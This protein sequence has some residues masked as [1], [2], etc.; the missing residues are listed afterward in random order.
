[1]PGNLSFW[2]TPLWFLSVGVTL[3][4]AVLVVLYSLLWLVSR[5]AAAAVLR[6]VQESVL[7]WI[8]YVVLV[9]VALCFL[10]TPMMPWRSVIDSV[11][12]LP[13]V[14]TKQVTVTIPP[15]TDDQQV[16][17][18]F[19]SDELQR[20]SFAA[21]Q[22]VIV[23]VE[24]MKAYSDPLIE[25]VA[26]EPYVW[27]P[28]SKIDRKF[29]GPITSLYVTNQSDAPANLTIESTTDVPIVEARQ[30]FWT[31]AAVVGVYLIYLLQTWLLPSLSAI[32][33]ATAKEAVAQPLYLLALFGGMGLLLLVRLH[34]VQHVRRRREDVQGL[35]PDD[36]H[37]AGDPRRRCGRRA[38]R[39][40]TKS[41]AARPSRCSRSRSAAGSSCSASFSAS[42]GRSC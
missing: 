38:F 29:T 16:D 36:D 12:R 33:L 15:R 32:A 37:G 30:I 4:A 42:S 7:Q 10:A 41:K 11:R 35:G 20:Y 17:V 23:G 21:D 31:A 19:Q 40:P 1:M 5:P 18:E 13:H 22:D 28:S 27:T 14:G 34:P 24:P 25:I 26:D 8:S 39:W 9:Y 6:T 3:G 2:L